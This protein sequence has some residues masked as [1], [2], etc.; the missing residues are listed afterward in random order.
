AN[1]GYKGL[2]IQKDKVIILEIE[3]TIGLANECGLF[4]K[5]I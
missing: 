5:L 3:R 2:A 1:Y 4:I